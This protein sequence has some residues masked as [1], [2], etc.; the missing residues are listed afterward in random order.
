MRWGDGKRGNSATAPGLTAREES[1]FLS[2][3]PEIMTRMRAFLVLSAALLLAGC[4]QTTSPQASA[5]ERSPVA[6]QSHVKLPAGAPCT[7][8]LERFRAIIDSDLE[9]GNVGQKVHD[10]MISEM[11][12]PE[13]QCAAGNEGGSHA[14][15][16]SVKARHGYH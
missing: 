11:R 14:A 4:N 12:Q 6:T 5:P 13:S 10:S 16:A 1:P 9:T 7:G 8:E 15:L 3:P 2:S